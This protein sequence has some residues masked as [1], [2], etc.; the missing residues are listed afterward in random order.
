MEKE[1][2][3]PNENFNK[4]DFDFFTVVADVGGNHTYIAV[5]GIRGKKEFEII[6]KHTHITKDLSGL[7]EL[8]NHAL[9]EAKELY[10]IEINRC[11]I[12]AAGPVTKKREDITLSHAN[13]N[14]NAKRI[15]NNTMLNKVILINDFEAIGYGIDL[16][17]NVKDAQRIPPLGEDRVT[18]WVP[19][20]TFAVLGAGTGLGMSI[21]HYDF[22]RHV[23]VPL[24]SEGGHMDYSAEDDFEWDFVKYLKEE[25][26]TDKHSQPELEHVLSGGGMHHIYNFL[27]K[28]KMGDGSDIVAKIDSLSCDE[29]L[30]AIEKNYDLDET[31]KKVVDMFI[32]IYARAARNLALVS[33]CYSGLFIGGGIALRLIDRFMDGQFMREFIKH[34]SEKGLLEKDDDRVVY[35]AFHCM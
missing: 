24:P 26:L 16:I 9:F 11:C 18:G 19:G 34:D 35:G 14:I 29:R 31:C 32:T 1:V 33:E 2:I 10:D 27:R 3:I 20:H 22:N 21:L 8:I 13:L 23:H 4:A 17:D 5:M 7:I 6:F 25:V 12:G 28:K 30:I 15:L